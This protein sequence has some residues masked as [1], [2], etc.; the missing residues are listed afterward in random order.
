MIKALKLK[1]IDI[2]DLRVMSVYLQ[3]AVTVPG[4]ISYL[5]KHH[6]FAAM[7]NRYCWEAEAA[8]HDDLPE[9]MTCLRVR[10]GLHFDGILKV[11]SQ[12]IPRLLKNA[13][14]ELLAIDCE[15]GVDGAAIITF[16]FA[17]GSTIRLHGECIDA[18]LSDVS[19]PWPARCEPEHAALAQD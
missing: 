11:E 5:G 2:D 4:D 1:A 9:G 3:D 18:Y 7:F 19:S 10:T 15:E 12:N 8:D 13:P 14:L 17:G 16:I 6:R